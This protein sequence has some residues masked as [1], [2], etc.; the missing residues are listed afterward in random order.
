MDNKLYKM[1]G[2]YSKTTERQAPANVKFALRF[3][4]EYEF[5]FGSPTKKKKYAVLGFR[6]ELLPG[7]HRE[8]FDT[9]LTN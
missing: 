3:E 1:N 7:L 6:D 5:P 9:A 2:T 4:R 8:D